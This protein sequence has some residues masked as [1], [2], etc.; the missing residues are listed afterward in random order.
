MN[1]ANLFS[2]FDL[3]VGKFI[4]YGVLAAVLS[5]LFKF[6]QM[7]WDWLFSF[8]K[9]PSI[10]EKKIDDSVKDLTQCLNEIKGLLENDIKV[11]DQKIET[12]ERNETTIIILLQHFINNL[13]TWINGQKNLFENI[14]MVEKD[15]SNM[16]EM[17]DNLKNGNTV[18]V[19]KK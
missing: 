17:V 11:L 14:E 16:Q 12:L 6:V 4:F 1:F 7:G 3:E 9:K 2:Q 15:L 19:P 10:L 18:K 13:K 5:S 8:F